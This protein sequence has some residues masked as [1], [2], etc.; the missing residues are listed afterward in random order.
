LVLCR[1]ADMEDAMP[2]SWKDRSGEEKQIT[3]EAKL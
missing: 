3:S 1:D 2:G